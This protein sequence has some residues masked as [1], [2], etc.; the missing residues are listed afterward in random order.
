MRRSLVRDSLAVSI[1]SVLRK[2]SAFLREGA[3]A[4][5]FG[6]GPASD[7]LLAAM[8]LP[9]LIVGLTG[10]A[11]GTIVVPLWRNVRGHRP[12]EALGPFN[13][14]ILAT[15]FLLLLL[16]LA[17]GAIVPLLV[18]GFSVQETALTVA[19][20]RLLLAS[21]LGLV[22]AAFWKAVLEAEGRFSA[23][24]LSAL[25]VNLA[26]GA[27][28]LLAARH[29]VTWAAVAAVGAQ[30]LELGWLFALV[31]RHLPAWRPDLCLSRTAAAHI[32]QLVPALLA[33]F[34]AQAGLVAAR[35]FASGLP[36][37]SLSSLVYA[38]QL[39]SFV[40]G[41]SG[42]SFVTAA[43][44]R[45]AAG[46]SSRA[47]EIERA[48]G[49]IVFVTLPL[50]PLLLLVAPDIVAAALLRGRFAA[51]ALSLTTAA[52]RGF[53]AGLP[54]SPLLGLCMR[55][56]FARREG[57]VAA[58]ASAASV[59][60]MVAGDLLLAA[61]LGVYGMAVAA[62]AGQAA[63]LVVAMATLWPGRAL[64]RLR[65]GGG[66][67]VPIAL[68][69]LPC[70]AVSWLWSY[71]QAGT[72]PDLAVAA[73]ALLTYLLLAHL[74]RVPEAKR[75]MGALYRRASWRPLLGG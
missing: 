26:S 75:I 56:A 22:T 3:L 46:A 40:T 8:G 17:A 52:F 10:A 54:L 62:S 58:L 19:L 50:V 14:M 1:G 71:R 73:A 44:P 61:P 45:L 37:G 30:F 49:W 6:A 47:R 64:Q 24:A 18:P 42:G 16:E 36:A 13:L 74:A 28:F 41:V 2:A 21:S 23:A 65:T 59:G 29:G 34:V 60:V 12:E 31:R 43:Y 69:A 68:C 51:G 5:A 27:G 32:P 39:A 67:L 38:F 66:R 4:Y 7:A 20:T 35:I 70:A 9:S 48:F 25:P 55:A 63:G 57:G 53:V 11:I 72:V 15:A 33:A